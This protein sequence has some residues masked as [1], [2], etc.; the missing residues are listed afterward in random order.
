GGS[1]RHFATFTMLDAIKRLLS[2]RKRDPRDNRHMIATS[3]DCGVRSGE[4][5]DLFC[6]KI[7]SRH[8]RTSWSA[9]GTLLPEKAGFLLKHFLMTQYEQHTEVMLTPSNASLKTGFNQ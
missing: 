2:G 9:G 6:T 5:H 1:N 4:L 7:P 8:F 3:P